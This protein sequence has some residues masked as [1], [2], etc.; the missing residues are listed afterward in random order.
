MCFCKVRVALAA[1]TWRD[2]ISDEIDSILQRSHP[3][4]EHSHMAPTL[5]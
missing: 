2:R 1:A 5:S 3:P 4:L